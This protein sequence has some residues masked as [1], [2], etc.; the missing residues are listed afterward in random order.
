MSFL[1]SKPS[2]LLHFAEISYV[3]IVILFFYI[4]IKIKS[5][6]KYSIILLNS[7][8][9][10]EIAFISEIIFFYIL[11]FTPI[12]QHYIFFQNHF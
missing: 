1:S 8:H 9:Y 2:N 4:S 6:K 3:S 11:Y 12:Y 5:F 7:S 10:S